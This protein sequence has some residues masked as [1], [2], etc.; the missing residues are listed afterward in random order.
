MREMRGDLGEPRSKRRR[1]VVL[2]ANVSSWGAQARSF[3]VIEAPDV[4]VVA[5]THLAGAQ[6]G[7]ECRRLKSVKYY[8][9]GAAAR[10][11]PF[12]LPGQ[13]ACYAG[14]DPGRSTTGGLL[15]VAQPYLEVAGLHVVDGGEDVL[16][17]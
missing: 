2:F 13:R 7:D 14:D 5:E 11:N 12:S 3:F 10:P 8:V 16:Q 15:L 1:F 6:F 9:T 17:L 4:A